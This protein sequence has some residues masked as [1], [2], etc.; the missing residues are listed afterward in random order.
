[1]E[2]SRVMV[3]AAF[4]AALVRLAVASREPYAWEEANLLDALIAMT[5]KDYQLALDRIMASQ[6]PPTAAEVSTII[7]RTLLTRAEIRDRFED[8]QADRA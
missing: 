3:L 7:K 2:Q 1:M 8:L 5:S 6:R 4:E